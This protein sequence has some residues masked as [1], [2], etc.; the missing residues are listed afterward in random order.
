MKNLLLSSRSMSSI[1]ALPLLSRKGL[2]CSSSMSE[3]DFL[4]VIKAVKR[5]RM[6][7]RE[8]SLEN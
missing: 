1:S 2:L 3:Q 5:P 4:N 7:F 6:Q 8:A